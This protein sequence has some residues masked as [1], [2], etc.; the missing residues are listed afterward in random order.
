LTLDAEPGRRDSPGWALFEPIATKTGGAR[1]FRPA[2]N[3]VLSKPSLPPF[4]D[5]CMV[6]LIIGFA[7][8][9][10]VV[11]LSAAACIASLALAAA[12]LLRYGDGAWFDGG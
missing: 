2:S 3:D 8:F 12:S 1:R 9:I 7:S 10:I 11:L 5:S 6:E 4:K